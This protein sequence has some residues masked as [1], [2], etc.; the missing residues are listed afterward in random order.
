MSRSGLQKFLFGFDKNPEC[1]A[2]WRAGSGSLFDGFD[3]D[4]EER[5]VLADGDLATL[6]EWGVHP[7][8]IRNFSGTIGI[9]YVDAYAERG[10]KP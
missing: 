1:L 7:L 8:L 5:R 3:L 10:L 2:K 4:T 9:R 6:Y